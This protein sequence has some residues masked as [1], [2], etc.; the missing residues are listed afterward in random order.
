VSL[1]AVLNMYTVPVM[2]DGIQFPAESPHSMFC[3]TQLQSAVQL[4]Q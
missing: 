3:V 4:P 2:G 1:H